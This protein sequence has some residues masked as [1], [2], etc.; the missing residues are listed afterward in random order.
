MTLGKQRVASTFFIVFFVI[1]AVLTLFSN[2]FQ[3]AMLPK[4]VTEKPV[5]KAWEHSVT[6]SGVLIPKHTKVLLSDNG[7]RVS[8]IHV[9]QHDPVKKGQP[10]VTFDAQEA[11]EQ[12]LDEEIRWKKQRLNR[13]MLEEQYIEAQRSGN[14]E[15]IRKVRRDIEIETLDADIAQRKLNG[16]RKSLHEKRTLT[17][18][19]DGIVEE[20]EAQEGMSVP[21]GQPL[22]TLVDNRE[23]YEF[24]FK[25]SADS[26]VLLRQGDTVTV[27]LDGSAS[28]R[29][30]GTIAKI[31]DGPPENTGGNEM[32]KPSGDSDGSSG[33][34]K[35]H[36]TIVIAV[37]GEGI[38][39]GE[40][41]NV[42]ID[43]KSR[44]QGL[45]IRKELIKKDGTG[46]YV[47]V[48]REKKSPLGNA[49]FAQKA[50]VTTGESSDDEI[51]VL[52]GLTA[53]DDI[54]V[55]SSEPL[56]DGNQVRLNG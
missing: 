26:T 8:N 1:L 55:Q 18:P 15:A 24:S 22:L 54:V 52:S 40:Q 47:F 12:L 6:G 36:K 41:A 5:K 21:R 38:R 17:A 48:V 13:D 29:L 11:E 20:L 27:S 42:R 25:A 10:L 35:P 23:G 56:Q 50:Y 30:E 53:K 7:W 39:G 31:K 9:A 2:T 33:T 4:A 16:L 19:I 3:T 51:V 43:K 32:G 45:V 14:E 46:S 49:Y 44:E 28:R 34:S 37:S